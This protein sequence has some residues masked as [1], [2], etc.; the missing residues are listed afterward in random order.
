MNRAHVVIVAGGSGTRMQSDLP[1]QFLLLNE[2]P[3]LIHTIEKFIPFADTL[4]LVLPIA[5]S[6]YWE[7]I[8]IK[9][10]INFQIE[11]VQGGKERFFSVE[12]AL[13]TLP[14][15]GLV[16]IHDAVRPL[17]NSEV[18]ERVIE[19]TKLKGNA[20]PVIEITDS[21]RKQEGEHSS[22]VDRS[23][24]KRIQT[25]Q[26]FDLK[27]LKQAYENGF[28]KEYTDDASVFE[29]IGHQINLVEGHPYNLK[30]TTPDDLIMA[31]WMLTL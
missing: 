5:W 29:S 3:V 16:L 18:I 28:R 15:N 30:I 27:E 22:M 1:K 25:P 24:Y 9:Y 6:E 8:K 13:K 21:I 31:Q 11:L 17:V 2:K 4:T 23:Q 10:P 19:T 12:N 26:G 7:S 14:N 20:I